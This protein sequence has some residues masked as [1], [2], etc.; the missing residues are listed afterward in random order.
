MGQTK[1]KSG[2]GDYTRNPREKQSEGPV[3]GVLRGLDEVIPGFGEVVKGLEKSEAFQKRL[4]TANAEVERRLGKAPLS[5]G[6]VSSRRAPFQAG[7]ALK[8][9][10]SAPGKESPVPSSPRD[11][12][13][14]IFD[15]GDNLVIIA[16]LPGVDEKDIK[17]AVKENR[18][19]L[20]ARSQSRQY[21]REIVLP[22][23]VKEKP[24]LTYK[25]GILKISLEKEPK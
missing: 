11:V 19:K 24:G 13:A 5:S 10:R 23:S 6:A 2:R 4:E 16:E 8:I 9:N 18:L 22:C 1:G 14:D 7:R 20:F 17:I 12:N 3:E 21:N 25:N 15:E